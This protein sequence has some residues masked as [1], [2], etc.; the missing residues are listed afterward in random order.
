[1]IG[2]VLAGLLAGTA[3]ADLIQQHRVTAK[4]APKTWVST[5]RGTHV[6]VYVYD[7][8]GEIVQ[9]WVNGCKARYDTPWVRVVVEVAD[10]HDSGLHPY[11]ITYKSV[12][13]PEPLTFRLASR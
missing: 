12:G 6:Y 10:C 8:M 4:K 9:E 5:S 1:M 2:V 13:A 7:R 11:R 3:R